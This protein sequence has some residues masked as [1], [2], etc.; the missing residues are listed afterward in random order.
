MSE[1]RVKE[2]QE[3][4]KKFNK[5]LKE[6]YSLYETKQIRFKNLKK[7][8]SQINNRRKTEGDELPSVKKTVKRLF[9]KKCASNRNLF[10]KNPEWK[11]LRGV[12]DYFE[13]FKG[14]KNKYE[15][16]TWEKV[17]KYYII[18]IFIL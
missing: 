16:D 3:F 6:A 17:F 5:D 1:K 9:S 13:E 14:L 7:C 15:L 11:P 8:N 12:P 10:I 18:I 4:I 2:I